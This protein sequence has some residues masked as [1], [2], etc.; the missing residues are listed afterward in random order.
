MAAMTPLVSQKPA[1]PE[2]TGPVQLAIFPTPS[3]SEV[4]KAVHCL[5][6]CKLPLQVQSGGGI[7]SF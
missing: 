4:G 3:F 7:C 1:M 5:L 6:D 2:D